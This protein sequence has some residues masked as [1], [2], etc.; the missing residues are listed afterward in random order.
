VVRFVEYACVV[1]EFGAGEIFLNDGLG[2]REVNECV[3]WQGGAVN[4]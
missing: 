3:H 2:H 4:L 1:G